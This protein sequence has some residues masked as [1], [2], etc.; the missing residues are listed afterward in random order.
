MR[1][2]DNVTAASSA[3][4]ARWTMLALKRVD[5]ELYDA[6][7]EQQSLYYEATVQGSADD[8]K[9]HGEALVRGYAEA[10]FT[11]EQAEH[12][13]DAYLIGRHN[14]VVVVI[15]NQKAVQTKLVDLAATGERA[16]LISPD[17]VALL[18][19]SIEG[20]LTI[21]Q[22]FPGAE[23]IEPRIDRYPDEPAKGDER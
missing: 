3:F 15:S 1:Q 10:V 22:L 11:M 19:G 9:A 21:K 17:E 14:G 20:L 8:I 13:D 2:D 7:Q 23:V 6:L 12:P 5:G 16:I 18:L 4:E